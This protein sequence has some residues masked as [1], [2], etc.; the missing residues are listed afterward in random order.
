M[1][2]IDEMRR[3]REERVA[4]SAKAPVKAV[5]AAAPA[6]SGDTEGR[7]PTCGKTKPV[8][9]GVMANHQQG[10][11]KPCAGSRKPPA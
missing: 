11:G 8:A 1:S 5:K 2:K 7:C 10:L 6:A 4:G 9:N 3:Q